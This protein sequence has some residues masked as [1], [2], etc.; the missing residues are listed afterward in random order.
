MYII[1]FPAV[2]GLIDHHYRYA[3]RN[4]RETPEKSTYLLQ[5]KVDASFVLLKAAS[6]SKREH[7]QLEYDIL[8][9]IHSPLLPQAISC[10]SDDKT[11]YFLR[12]YIAGTPVSDFVERQPYKT[13]EMR[14]R[15][16]TAL[17]TAG[18]P[19]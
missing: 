5:R 12:E 7:L 13:A 8:R 1:A 11:T 18:L 6:G 19:G 3:E 2:N 15:I 4:H 16:A 10:F 17:Q 9:S 14:H